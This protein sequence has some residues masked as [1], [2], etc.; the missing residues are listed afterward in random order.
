[1]IAVHGRNFGNALRV[2]LDSPESEL[3]DTRWDVRIGPLELEPQ[4]VKWADRGTL[5]VL[6]PG[7]LALG[8]HDVTV[9]APSG[10]VTSLRAGLTVVEEPHSSDTAGVSGEMAST[11]QSRTSG[12]ESGE[13]SDVPASTG[14]GAG[15][16][17]SSSTDT[18]A[19][20][21]AATATHPDATSALDVSDAG[22]GGSNHDR[23]FDDA[24]AHTGDETSSEQATGSAVLRHR[25][26]F[27]QSGTVVV[28]SVSG[29]NGTFFGAALDGVSGAATFMGGGQYIDLPNGLISGRDAVTIETWLIWDAPSEAPVHAWQRVFDFGSSSAPEG[30]QGGQDTHLFLSPR[31]GGVTGT[32]HLA[33]RGNY[34]G[35]VTLNG[36][37]PLTRATMQH[38]VAVVDGAG[39]QMQLYVDGVVV[40]SR[41][42]AYS[43]ALIDDH[44]NW[45]GRSQVLEDPPF[46]GR[47]FEF[48]VYEGVLSA[49]SISASYAAGPDAQ[50]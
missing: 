2:D 46:T 10:V 49:Q 16:G 5:T 47:I 43:L 45:L 44:N 19:D 33:Y 18:S 50:L 4:A 31:S 20:A 8:P 12:A 39:G 22:A 38:V 35:S 17:N 25:Y 26:S 27:E 13:T 9:V 36:I 15:T 7:T 32:V 24:G 41:A 28:D 42:L 6:V 40:A 3:C 34:T 23:T 37:A 30:L 11:G 21:G 29:A 14:Q 48:R 1:M